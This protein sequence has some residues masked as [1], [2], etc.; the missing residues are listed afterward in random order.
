MIYYPR[1]RLLI[2]A[3]REGMLANAAI[4]KSREKGCDHRVVF[5]GELV[6]KRKNQR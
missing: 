3:R 1:T 2:H 6:V 4:S 5:V